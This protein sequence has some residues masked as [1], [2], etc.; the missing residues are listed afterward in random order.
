MAAVNESLGKKRG[1][2]DL[3]V[4]G[5]RYHD[6]LQEVWV[7]T[8]ASCWIEAGEQRHRPVAFGGQLAHQSHLKVVEVMGPSPRSLAR[9]RKRSFG[10]KLCS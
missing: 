4:A 9:C 7:T 5:Q 2:E 6:A 10:F 1:P 8:W 3:R